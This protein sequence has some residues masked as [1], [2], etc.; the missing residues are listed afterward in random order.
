M[1]RIASL[2]LD[3]SAE[4]A[5]I[6]DSKPAGTKAYR[7]LFVDDEPNV[8]KAMRR[9]FRQEN[10]QLLT[11]GSGPEALALL[12]RH[13]PVHVVVSDHRMPG[14]TGTQLLKQIKAKYPKTIRIMLTGYADTDAVMGAVNEGA[15]YKFIT[16]PWNDDDLRLTVSLALEQYDLI[17]EN[18]SL[19]QQAENHQKEIKRLSRFVNAHHSQLGHLLLKAGLIDEKTLEKA[20]SIQAKSNTVLPK[21]LVNIGAISEKAIIGA[22]EKRTDINRVSPAE[23]SVPEALAAL[24]PREICE[25][26]MLVPLKRSDQKLIVAMAD[27]TDLNKIDDLTFI[28]GMPVQPV[29]ATGKE[30]L[31]TVKTIY[32]ETDVFDAVLS[33]IDLSD[34]TEQIEI[35]L[36][37]TDEGADIE[38]LLRAKDKPPAIRIVNAIISDALR[39]NASDVHIE[40]KTKYIMVRYRIDDLLVD[41]L[42]IPLNMHLA[43]VSRIKVMS[44]LDIAERRRPQDGRITVKS[45]TRMVDMRISTLPT[46]NGEK[47]VLR[48]LDKNAASKEIE[49]LGFSG[50]D[51]E[52]VIHFIERPQGIILATGPTGSG[53]TTTLYGMLRKGARITKNFTT[54]EDPV[55]YQ[56]G[57][58]EQVNVR[59][60]IG[61]SFSTV[62]RAI[63]RQDPNVIMLGEIRDHET[64]EV[65]FNAALTG[66][67]VLSTLHTNSSIAA[68]T[69]LRD[70]G[71]APYVISDALVGVIA[72]R[73]V[74]CTCPHCRTADHPDEQMRRSL[75]ITDPE[76]KAWR[77]AGCDRCNGIGY[78]GRIGVYEIF[79]VDREIKRM[80]HQDAAEPE[81]L[82]ATRLTGMSTLLDDALKKVKEGITTC[83]EVLRVFGPQHT[84]QIVCSHCHGLME[85]RHNYCPYCGKE[86]I[87]HCRQCG[88]LL[89]R[90]WH[91]CPKCGN[92]AQRDDTETGPPNPYGP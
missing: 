60:K 68:I 49:E 50:R 81:L 18:R 75:N 67:L 3:N 54:I 47:V 46:I 61:L 59:D 16:K 19:K 77:G 33:E 41:K 69:R 90:D 1:S 6:P 76:F 38:E 86:L 70:M 26:N 51:L 32:G 28:T 40:P 5:A 36:E 30:I 66:H 73:L 57:M 23:F 42:H 14:M 17:R 55:E 85:Q 8:L 89:A 63:L 7:I 88:Q 71:L 27:P 2:F 22:I 45:S 74:R 53:K 56:M 29:V 78:K 24:I 83:E 64:A 48:I 58:A 39:H 13:Q 31:A 87:K 92:T 82:H 65:A 79:Q 21:I 34:P 9:I 91:H 84:T 35:V 52:A 25:Q 62:L 11:A 12:D 44:D 37:E 15:V 10:Y 4:Q 43:I 72:Q 80:I 20:L